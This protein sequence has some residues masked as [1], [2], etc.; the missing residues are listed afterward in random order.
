MNINFIFRSGSK[1]STESETNTIDRAIANLMFNEIDFNAQ[2]LSGGS[3]S[4]SKH[5]MNVVSGQQ[6]DNPYV[7]QI[8]HSHHNLVLT[9]AEVPI[10]GQRDVPKSFSASNAGGKRKTPM[11]EFGS[12]TEF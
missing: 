11:S 5:E 12:T 9:D 4:D 8:S 6:S 7:P 1:K 2:D 10:L 3:S